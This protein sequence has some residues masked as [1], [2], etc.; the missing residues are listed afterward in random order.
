M[1]LDG[2]RYACFDI[3]SSRVQFLFYEF[4]NIHVTLLPLQF[5]SGNSTTSRRAMIVPRQTQ[6]ADPG[7][8]EVD[9]GV[10]S[11]GYAGAGPFSVDMPVARLYA[12]IGFLCNAQN[13]E[14]DPY[15]Y[16][17]AMGDSARVCVRPSDYALD[18]GIKIRSIDSFTWA[19]KEFE[20]SQAAVTSNAQEAP[21]TEIFC[22]Q[23]EDTCAFQTKLK[24]D[25]YGFRGIVSGEGFVWLQIGSE[26]RRVQFEL[27]FNLLNDMEPGFAGASQFSVFVYVM[28]ESANR[29]LYRCRAYEC[30]KLNREIVPPGPKRQ[31]MSIRMCVAPEALALEKGARMW[32]VEWWHWTRKKFIQ[33]AVAPQGKEGP[34]GQTLQMCERGSE[35]CSFQTRLDNRL[36]NSSLPNSGIMATGAMEGIGY[37]W[38]T[39]GYGKHSFR[40]QEE[41][42]GVAEDPTNDPMFAGANSIGIMW[43]VEGNFSFPLPERCTDDHELKAWGKDETDQMKVRRDVLECDK[44]I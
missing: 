15:K 10:G 44:M 20:V 14:I 29:D 8:A 18:E 34:D 32:S 25:F 22:R 13:E 30:N 3:P 41:E 2:Y 12:A 17:L 1:G 38:L 9:G 28:P 42:T 6:E 27:G 23:G 4:L 19:R 16:P 35:V 11:I 7:P 24:D 26:S 5:G 36:F 31:G 33:A 37:C 40:G 43:P 39:F 21:E